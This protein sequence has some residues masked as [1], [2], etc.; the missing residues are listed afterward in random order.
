MIELKNGETLNGELINCDNWMNLTLKNV[1]Q[2]SSNGESFMK[3]PQVYIRGLHIKYLRLPDQIMD[4]AKE[5]NLIN[6]EQRNR[7]QKRRFNNNNNNNNHHN[8]HSNNNNS[9][10]NSNNNNNNNVRGDR[11]SRNN[12]NDRRGERSDRGNDRGFDRRNDSG[13]ERGNQNRN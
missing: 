10:N 9:N 4:Q 6:M 7:N 2:S 8:H 1:I 13:N 3:I 12:F 11:K 5:Q